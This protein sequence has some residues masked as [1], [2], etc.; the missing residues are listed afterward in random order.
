MI[1]MDLQ[2]SRILSTSCKKAPMLLL[3]A[4]ALGLL[5]VHARSASKGERYL[6]THDALQNLLHNS[7]LGRRPQ[8]LRQQRVAAL[9]QLLVADRAAASPLEQVAR[10]DVPMLARE[11]VCGLLQSPGYG[12]PADIGST[13]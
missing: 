8:A 1:R 6:H 2:A 11:H 12:Q 13:E 5:G 10:R 3:T 4:A 7:A 9:R